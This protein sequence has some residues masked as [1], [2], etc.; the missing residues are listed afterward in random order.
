MTAPVTQRNAFG[1]SKISKRALFDT[2]IKTA[3]ISALSELLWSCGEVYA[4]E[5]E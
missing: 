4:I 2:T 1:S 5:A 3:H